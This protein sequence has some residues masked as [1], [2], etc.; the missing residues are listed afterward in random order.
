MK[1]LVFG[2]LFFVSSSLIAQKTITYEEMKTITKGAFE[3]IECDVY[4]AK[5]G[6][7][8]KLGDT[9][10][11]G[12]PS[13]NK[14]FAFI[15]EGNALIAPKPADVSVSG[16]T[17]VIKKIYVGG[18]KRTGFSMYVVSK[19]M[20]SICPQYYINLEEAFASKELKSLGMSREEAIAKLKEAKDLV[21][22]GMMSKE[23]FEKLKAELTPL[24]IKN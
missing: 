2:L 16:N 18:T 22:L 5:D 23:D 17:T 6:H 7:S 24:I 10:K 11:I 8:Y 13:A 3:N 14:T 12:M 15:N 4:V 1:K 9:L 21:D 19:G 20:C